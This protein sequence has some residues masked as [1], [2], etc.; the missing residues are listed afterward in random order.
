VAI[1]FAKN[2]VAKDLALKF[3]YLVFRCI[4]KFCVLL[5]KIGP[6]HF[7]VIFNLNKFWQSYKKV[8]TFSLLLNFGNYI[9]NPTKILASCQKAK[10]W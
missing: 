6:V 3:C 9:R 7:D 10:I 5:V 8:A 2:L 4:L 1:F